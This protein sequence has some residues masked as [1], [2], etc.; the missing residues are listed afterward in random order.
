[1]FTGLIEAMGTIIS[2]NGGVLQVK[3]PLNEIAVG[4]SVSIN[5]I[6][7]TVT[8]IKQNLLAFDYTPETLA[9]TTMASLKTGQKVNIERA[10]KATERFGGHIVSGHVEAAG[11][12]LSITQAGNSHIFRFSLP[13][14]IARY[15]VA[16]GSIAVDGISLTVVEANNEWF[17][18]SVIPHT[19]ANTTLSLLK[20]GGLVNLEADVLAL[21]NEKSQVPRPAAARLTSQFLKENGFI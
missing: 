6:C 3:S 10:M 20:P 4:D 15:V 1:M 13:E 18:V 8:S 2:I 17:T 7:L 9:V 16:K 12:V 11:K 14:N 5:G 21:Y 19:M